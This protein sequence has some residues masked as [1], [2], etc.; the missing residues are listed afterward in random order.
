LNGESFWRV[1]DVH[2][3]AGW[4]SRDGQVR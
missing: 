1:L 3:S 4:K 2:G